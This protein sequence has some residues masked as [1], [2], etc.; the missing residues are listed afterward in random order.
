MV[1]EIEVSGQTF[2]A[3]CFRW[4]AKNASAKPL[5]SGTARLLIGQR[6]DSSLQF[7]EACHASKKFLPDERS[8]S[9]ILGFRHGEIL[10][11]RDGVWNPLSPRQGVSFR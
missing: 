11:A 10:L 6:D 1:E 2:A 7:R 3:S 4:V 5:K 8:C 9:R